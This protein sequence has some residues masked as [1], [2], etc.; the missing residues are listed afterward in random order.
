MRSG[1]LGIPAFYTPTGVGTF[2]EY[3]LVP[4]K[5]GKDGSTIPIS[6]SIPKERRVFNGRAYIMEETF[7]HADFS[8]VKA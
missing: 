3:G 7:M 4:T 6:T 8:I 5:Y 2:V 1:G